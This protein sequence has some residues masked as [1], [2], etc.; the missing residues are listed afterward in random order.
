MSAGVLTTRSDHEA[1][2]QPRTASAAAELLVVPRAEVLGNDHGGAGAEAGEEADDQIRDDGG[3]AAHR[4]QRR[5]PETAAHHDGVHCVIELEKEHP[6]KNGEEKA[7][8]L[9][10]DAPPGQIVFLIHK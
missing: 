1:E 3:T 5:R 10:H 6:E 4:R 2:N 9:P 7:R 8:Q